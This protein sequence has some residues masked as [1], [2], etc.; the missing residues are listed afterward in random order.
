MMKNSVLSRWIFTEAQTGKTRLGTHY[1]FI[2]KTNKLYVVDDN[3]ILIEDDI[4]K[5]II[6]NGGISGIT[7]FLVGAENF[8]GKISLKKI[9]F[10]IRTGARETHKV[11]CLK[12]LVEVTKPSNVSVP[13]I[14]PLT[15]LQ[16][17]ANNDL[18][19]NAVSR[20]KSFDPSI[21]MKEGADISYR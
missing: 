10:K 1:S 12:Y 5:A 9:L 17:Y 18:F 7:A 3:D 6:L 11:C 13:E 14:I 2:N 19:V 4:V 16:R 20:S 21:W 15:K 8:F